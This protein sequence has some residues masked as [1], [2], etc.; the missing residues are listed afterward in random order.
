MRTGLAADI[1]IGLAFAALGTAI[2][3]AASG[4]RTVP[5]MAVGSGLFPT[6]TGSAMILFGL[7][8]AIGAARIA[9]RPVQE[10]VAG[11]RQTQGADDPSGGKRRLFD[12]YAVALIVALLVLIAAM[13]VAGFLV[14]GFAFAVF[15]VRLGGGRWVPAIVFSAI[16]TFC[17]HFVF[18]SGLRVPLPPGLF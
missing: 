3:V 4:F 16:A 15:A 7:L 10:E 6:M 14:A 2:I 13:P 11:T 5:G 12:G 1:V 9:R 17:I 18:T 8:M